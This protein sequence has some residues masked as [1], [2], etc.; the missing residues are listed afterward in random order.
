[1]D[2]IRTGLG[3]Q[4]A[5]VFLILVQAPVLAGTGR[6]EAVNGVLDLTSGGILGLLRL[7]GEWIFR[8]DDGTVDGILPV[9]GS[10]KNAVGRV[11]SSGT[12]ELRIRLPDDTSDSNAFFGLLVPELSQVL[13]VR[14]NG[15]QAFASGDMETGRADFTRSVL[16]V[17]AAEEIVLLMKIRNTQFRDGGLLYAPMFGPF[18]VIRRFREAKIWVE[19]LIMGVFFLVAVHH[20]MLY[21]WRYRNVSALYL[22]AAAALMLLRGLTTGE[23]I[24]A[25]LFPNFPWTLDYRIEYISAYLSAAALLRF[26]DSTFPVRRRA[27]TVS[28]SALTAVILV[29]SLVSAVLP[30][31]VLSRTIYALEGIILASFATG[32]IILVYALAERKPASV[33]FFWGGMAGVVLF[34]ADSAYYFMAVGGLFSLA[35]VGMLVFLLV[36]TLVLSR[37]YGDAFLR[38]ERLTKSLEDEVVQRTADLE[39][40]NRSLQVEIAERRRAEA[41]LMI[42]STTD[43]LTG[44]ANR[45]KIN[46]LLEQNHHVFQRYR[47]GYGLIMFDLDHFKRV[48]DKYGHEVG[49]LVLK[50]IVKVTNGVIRKCDV[51]ARWGGEEFLI[52]LPTLNLEGTDCAAHRIRSALENAEFPEAGSVT[53]SF[54]AAV[55]GK[56]EKLE[57]LLTRLDG[58]L[59]R[60]K[61]EGRNRV[62]SR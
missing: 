46:S 44:A 15:R 24:V 40:T 59:Y 26:L 54:G 4:A 60:A 9:P 39:R 12:Y 3:F 6:P 23:N 16:P 18:H 31:A 1:M 8:P 29:M 25:V 61:Q 5:A 47:I 14:V 36:Q 51:L 2:R 33:L 27:A 52:L 30:I 62:T 38:A 56:D 13:E 57:D 41:R 21:M 34:L 42:L 45:N 20:F 50:E 28:V 17:E 22:G 55:P 7:E 11:Y 32:L 37:I 35:Q 49:D 58:Y 19:S 43:P 48:N 10:W 53:A